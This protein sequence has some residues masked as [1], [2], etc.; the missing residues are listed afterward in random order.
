MKEEM[1]SL[2]R[3]SFL[4]ILGLT[5]M[6]CT[7]SGPGG[8]LTQGTD[9]AS[10]RAAHP[11][12]LLRH[13]PAPQSFDPAVT[14]SGV[15]EITFKSGA[16]ALKAWIGGPTQG[17]H[18]AVVFLHGG[19]AFGG[20]DWQMAAPLIEQGF[21]VMM[22]RLRGENGNPGDYEMFFGEVDDAVAAGKWLATQ[23]GV[24]AGR[25]YVLGHSAGG[26]L[27]CL[28]AMIDS[29]Y[30]EASSMGASPDQDVFAQGQPQ[31]VPFDSDNKI[32]FRLRSPLAFV[33]SLRI[34]LHMFLGE[35]ERVYVDSSKSMVEI[36]TKAGKKIELTIVPGT[37][38]FTE[39]PT[40]LQTIARAWAK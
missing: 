1:R 20:E 13:G 36:G 4:V 19:F 14:P 12:H 40:A 21:V 8:A 37:D 25:L 23:P 33:S 2:S 5:L 7:G 22:P 15:R 30:K 16:L 31:I 28:A 17:K 6:S 27:A 24:D 32:E 29:P 11:T 34:P 3:Q 10:E 26:T 38:H 9:L 18:P 35:S 39:V